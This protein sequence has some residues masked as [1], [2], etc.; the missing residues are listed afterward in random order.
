MKK[1]IITGNVGRDPE[2]R[3]DQSGAAFA[4]F[5]VG[6]NVGNKQNPKTD[7]VDIS[8]SGKLVD[9]ARN[10]VRKGSKILIEGFPSVSAYMNKENKPAA[11]LRI[12]AN[13]LELLS[14]R[15]DETDSPRYD[16]ES[17][18]VYNLPEIGSGNNSAAGLKSDDIPF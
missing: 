11:S 4:T 16:Y 2:V 5:S 6:V 17:E 8:C 1:I 18:P 14:K 12:Y 3:S 7:W 13:V 9:I 15:E 10:Y